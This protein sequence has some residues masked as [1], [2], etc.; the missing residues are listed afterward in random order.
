M[1]DTKIS[2]AVRDDLVTW[3][4]LNVVAFLA[5]AVA[6]RFPEAIGEPYRDA[7]GRSYLPIL[8]QPVLILAGSADALA[9][10]HRRA[11]ER[12]LELAVYSEGMFRTGNDADNRAVVAALPTDALDLVGIATRAERK[13][14]DKAFKGLKLQ[15]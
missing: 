5:S 4:K 8:G 12:G 6:A 14:V 10:G 11:V 7:G 9:K 1:H 13:E 15:A 2:I 3:Q